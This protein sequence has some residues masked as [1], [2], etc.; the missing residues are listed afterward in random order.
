MDRIKGII[1]IQI[2]PGLWLNARMEQPRNSKLN[3]AR[4]DMD[5]VR[6]HLDKPLAPNRE[7]RGIGGILKD[8]LDGLEE[9]QCENILILRKAWPQLVGEQIAQHSQPGFIKDFVLFV[10]IDLPGWLPEL[11]RIKR[12]LLQKIQANYRELRIR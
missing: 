1:W 3:Q 12:M 2:N 10:Y 6:F 8:V 11:E 9:P 7:I 4:W 5:K